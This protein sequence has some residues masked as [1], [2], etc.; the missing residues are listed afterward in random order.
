MAKAVVLAEGCLGEDMGKTANG[1]VLHSMRD[2]IVAAIDSTKAGRDAGEVIT[3]TKNG[4]P[5]VASFDEAYRR[6]KP[7]AL[8]LGAATVGGVLPP[9]FTDTTKQALGKGMVVYNGLHRFLAEESEFKALLSNGARIVDVRKP[10]EK[11]RVADG[12][13][14]DLAT[15]RVLVMGTDCAV[16]K[17][18]TVVELVKEARKR[19]IN[20]GFVATG[21][22]G[23][24]IG[25]DAGAVIDRIPSDFCAGMVEQMCC[26]VAAQGR[27]M[28][29]VYGQSS[30]LHPAYSGVSLSILHGSA[31]HAVILQHDP[32]RKQRTL[33][34]NPAYKVAP[35]KQE[36]ELIERLG[37]GKVVAIAI[38][39]KD[40]AD[41][42]AETAAISKLT[43]LPAV[44]PLH[45]SAS[46]LLET[47]LEHLQKKRVY[48]R[49]AA[50]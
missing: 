44:D 22:T 11:L 41:I 6:F 50:T 15:P 29:F 46:L 30:I 9:W 42:D 37:T 8:Y 43:G 18:M 31:P 3:G 13:I 4:V 26:D 32:V 36:I 5:V 28:I 19:G 38:N 17:R 12:R 10:P 7:Q 24:M 34:T 40:C 48:P 14:Y 2:E 47:T 45:R 35:L 25:P 20:A 16:G 33:F 1:L 49:L 23:C 21:Q 39:G 27:D